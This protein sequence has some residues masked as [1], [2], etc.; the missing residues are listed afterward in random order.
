MIVLSGA[1]LVSILA[2]GMAA[3]QAPADHAVAA[4]P[5]VR[6]WQVFTDP[7]EGAFQ[8]EMPQGWKVSGGT[9][10]RNALQYRTWAWWAQ[11]RI[12]HPAHPFTAST[13][14]RRSSQ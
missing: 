2:G 8:L 12:L 9:A 13:V 6:H 3:A 11:K 10:R 1:V 7:Q 5:V 4:L 14:F